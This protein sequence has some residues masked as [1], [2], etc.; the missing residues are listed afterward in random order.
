MRGDELIKNCA[1]CFIEGGLSI[2]LEEDGAFL[3]C[4]RNKK[5]KYVIHNGFLR[6][7]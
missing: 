6:K 7:V 2:R 3:V 1:A 4:P 5:H